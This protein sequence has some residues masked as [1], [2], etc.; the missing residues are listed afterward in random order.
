[1]IDQ[2]K[3][4]LATPI[5]RAYS[6]RHQ[7]YAR[8]LILY[9]NPNRY[10]YDIDIL[11]DELYGFQCRVVEI[12]QGNIQIHLVVLGKFDNDYVHFFDIFVSDDN[13]VLEDESHDGY[14]PY[15]KVNMLIEKYIDLDLPYDILS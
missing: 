10:F 11:T 6:L 5:S 14:I 8:A 15:D 12:V 3:T 13:K 2:I 9:K 7:T 1:M 4:C